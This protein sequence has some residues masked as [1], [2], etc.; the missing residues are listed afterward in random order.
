MDEN[1]KQVVLFYR[2][3]HI[4]RD[5]TASGMVDAVERDAKE[6][7]LWPILQE[8]LIGVASDGAS[9]MTGN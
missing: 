8:R 3:V 5:E 4:G 6:D 2:L 1:R 7:G 9:V